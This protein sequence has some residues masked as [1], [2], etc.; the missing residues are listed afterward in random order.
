MSKSNEVSWKPRIYAAL[1]IMAI[2]A[3][4]IAAG[5]GLHRLYRPKHRSPSPPPPPLFKPLPL[6]QLGLSQSQWQQVRSVMV[7]DN[8]PHWLSTELYCGLTDEG[9]VWAGCTTSATGLL[10]GAHPSPC[11][12]CGSTASTG[13][14][15]RISGL[16]NHQSYQFAVVAVDDSGNPSYVSEVISATPVP[17]TDFAEAYADAGGKEQGGFCFVATELY[18]SYDHPDVRKLRRFRDEVLARSTAG[19]RFIA[20]YYRHGRG[21]ARLTRH[22]PALRTLAWFGVKT[23]VIVSEQVLPET[24]DE[25]PAHSSWPLPTA[26]LLAIASFMI[27]RRHGISCQKVRGSNSGEQQA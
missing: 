20:W 4:G 22:S 15:V 16:D 25:S 21:L 12:V 11:Y 14:S 2:F 10:E 19:R 24:G 6:E 27:V 3:I 26:L 1:S 7:N 8:T 17:T 18:G 23:L 9:D 13:T 5:A